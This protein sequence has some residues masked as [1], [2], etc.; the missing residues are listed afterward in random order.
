MIVAG[1]GDDT[2]RVAD[3]SGDSV[4]CGDG[5]DTAL[6]D[7][8]D[9]IADATAENPNGSCE[10]VVRRAPRVRSG[11]GDAVSTPVAAP[12][13]ARLPLRNAKNKNG[14]LRPAGRHGP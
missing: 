2:I 5:N 6:L 10:T 3:D 8:V 7:T 1:Y 4:D 9:V 12:V 14:S 13:I 11:R